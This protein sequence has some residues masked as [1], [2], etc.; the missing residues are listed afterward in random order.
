MLFKTENI[1]EY[2]MLGDKKTNINIAITYDEENDITKI[3]MATPIIT[4]DF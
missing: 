1:K 4:C 3:Y 2:I